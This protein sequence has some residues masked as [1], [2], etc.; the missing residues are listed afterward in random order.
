M[1][2]YVV[3][4][5]YSEGDE[6]QKLLDKHNL[7]ILYNDSYEWWFLHWVYGKD[8]II[9][10]G[11]TGLDY[12]STFFYDSEHDV[13]IANSRLDKNHRKIALYVPFADNEETAT[14]GHGTH[15]C[16]T[17]AGKAN[18]ESVSKYNVSD[19]HNLSFYRDWLMMLDWCLLIL[20]KEKRHSIYQLTCISITI[21][22]CWYMFSDS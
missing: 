14:A 12:R 18:D 21:L 7:H 17:I 19:I 20:Q 22:T 10:V 1:R 16:G 5:Q 11:D 9:G 15:V 3:D 4:G 13:R 2:Q 6:Q 8:I